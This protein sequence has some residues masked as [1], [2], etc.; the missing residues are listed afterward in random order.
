MG[1]NQTVTTD[2]ESI[3]CARVEP[4]S[5]APVRLPYVGDSAWAHPPLL[6]TV[7]DLYPPALHGRERRHFCASGQ[8][9]HMDVVHVTPENDMI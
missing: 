4:S 1:T 9:F 7:S 2:G 6:P 5:R 3:G 8:F